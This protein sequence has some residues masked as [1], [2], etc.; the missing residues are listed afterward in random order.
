[1]LSHA[2][3]ASR[4]VLHSEKPPWPQEIFVHAY[5]QGVDYQAP[6]RDLYSFA[7]PPTVPMKPTEAT[8]EA[9]PET[10][11]T[12]HT[13][14]KEKT[15]PEDQAAFVKEM[16]ERW[17][18]HVQPLYPDKEFDPSCVSGYKT[19]YLASI[20]TFN[21]FSKTH[22]ACAKTKVD[23][24]LYRRGVNAYMKEDLVKDVLV[25]VEGKVIYKY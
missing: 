23:I 13:V 6:K 17:E 18:R 2:T 12:T 10:P 3:S 15:D 20:N 7:S 4:I 22:Y 21:Y 25:K 11:I 14:P 8:K 19:C 5:L 1:M 24:L 16:R 9:S